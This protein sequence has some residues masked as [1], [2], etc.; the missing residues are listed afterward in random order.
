MTRSKK[1]IIKCFSLLLFITNFS[2]FFPKNIEAKNIT[3]DTNLINETNYLEENLIFNGN[4]SNDINGW[5]TWPLD[6]KVSVKDNILFLDANKIANGVNQDVTL[7]SNSYYRLTAEMYS[8]SPNSISIGVKTNESDKIFTENK[9]SN[10]WETLSLEFNTLDNNNNASVKKNISVWLSKKNAKVRNIKLIEVNSI[11]NPTPPP[12]EEEIITSNETFYIDAENGNDNNDG[13]SEGTAWKTFNN[14]KNLRLLAGG[15]LLLKSGSTWNGEQLKIINAKGSKENPVII[16]KYGGNEKPIINGNGNP[17]QKNVNAVKQDV[18]TVHIYNSEYITVQDLEVTNWE[19]DPSDL[20]NDGENLPYQGIEVTSKIKYQQSKYLLT[21]ILIEN[22]DGGD[23]KGITVK[24]N[25]IHDINGLMQPKDRKGSGAL[26]ALVTGDEV[27]SKFTDLK[28]ISN[29]VNKVSHQSIYMESSWS[30]RD[31]VGSQQSTGKNKWIGWPNL[32]VAN[33]YVHDVAGDGIVLINAANGIAENNLVVKSASEDWNY[34]RNP[35]HAAI[36]MW[37]CNNVTMQYNEASN[38]ESYQDGMAFDFDY[39]NQN[40][41]YQYNYSHNNKGGFLMSCPGPFYTVN[42]VARYNISV[43]DGLFDGARILRIGEKGSI[44]NQFHNNTMY[45][46]HDYKVNAVEQAT[47]GTPP[48]SGTDIYN[49]IFYGDSDMFVN[50][51]GVSYSN[52]LVYGSVADVYP[53]DEDPNVII[54]DPQF[55]DVKNFKNGEFNNGKV[56]IG[57]TSG[58]SL[59]PNSPCIDSGINFKDIPQESFANLEDELVKTH[60]KIENKD[61]LGNK[62]PNNNGLIDIGAYEYQWNNSNQINKLNKSYLISLFNLAS[63]YDKN[64]FEKNSFLNLEKILANAKILIDTELTNQQAIDNMCSQLENAILSL[65]NLNDIKEADSDNSVNIISNHNTKYDNSNFE[66]GKIGNWTKWQ[67]NI[68]IDNNKA[69]LGNNSLKIESINFNTAFAELSDINVKPNTNYI[70]E[71]W[72]STDKNNFDKISIEAK[73][74]KNYTGSQDIK[75]GNAKPIGEP[76]NGWIKVRLDFKTKN[77][78]KISIS[79]NSDSKI[80][81]LDNITLFEKYIIDKESLD[82]SELD[83]AL[84][85]HPEN[86]ESYYSEETWNNYKEA[87]LSAKLARIDA[88]A[89]QKTVNEAANNLKNAFNLLKPNNDN[90][91][92]DKPNND[93]NNSDNQLV[94][95]GDNSKI[96]ISISLIILCTILLISIQ[97]KKKKI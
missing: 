93:N 9:T 60:I 66:D 74:H 10:S 44:G 22:H 31:I 6:T 51:D 28:I 40:I 79:L 94:A 71:G 89:T 15:K 38:T 18:A 91:N 86:K 97:F 5:N 92:S 52:N 21:G 72:V 48:S 41:L 85:L 96:F 11:P 73:H 82:F 49:N 47:W 56:T 43:N 16:G 45:W 54:A 88:L 27:E 14:V 8:E 30:A 17:W 78:N 4:F 69:Y 34:S 53:I 76:I 7:K 36:W 83:S 3:N 63:N 42:V 59:K 64:L 90:N 67:S 50:N 80:S 77:Y 23:L 39:G 55:V 70:I 65:I 68:S 84:L 25:Y 33:N 1:K 19:S 87:Y 81:W 75:L 29:E 61:Y 12:S 13:K 57:D 2:I 58:F 95:T 37:N 26:I 35:A 24:D 32:Y 46:D 20:M 62:V